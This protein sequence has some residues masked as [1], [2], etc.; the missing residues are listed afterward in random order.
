MKQAFAF[1]NCKPDKSRCPSGSGM[2]PAASSVTA[3]QQRNQTRLA[4][5]FV[6]RATAILDMHCSAKRRPAYRTRSVVQAAYAV[7]AAGHMFTGPGS[8]CGPAVVRRVSQQQQQ[9]AIEQ[10]ALAV[11]SPSARTRTLASVFSSRVRETVTL[12]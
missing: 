5:S 10:L 4:V 8:R 9:P 3:K 11:P 2:L 6:F 1:P 7:L 12:D